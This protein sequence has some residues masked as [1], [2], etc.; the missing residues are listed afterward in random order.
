MDH[1]A[2]TLPLRGRRRCNDL[3][4]QETVFTQPAAIHRPAPIPAYLGQSYQPLIAGMD[5]Y[6]ANGEALFD[7]FP[8]VEFRMHTVE[9]GY[10]VMGNGIDG[11]VLTDDQM[12]IEE[13]SCFADQSA[14]EPNA[15]HLQNA[16]IKGEFDEIFVGFDAAWRNYYHWLC[17]G[18][19]KMWYANTLVSPECKIV[20]PAYAELTADQPAVF[21]QQV[22]EKSISTVGLSDRLT[23][24]VPGVYRAKR[25]KF[26]WHF[27]RMPEMVAHLSP[28]HQYFN[29]VAKKIEPVEGLP[30][31]VLISREESNE[32]R[33]DAGQTELLTRV[34]TKFGF[35]K[36]ILG[37]MSF[38]EQ[39][40]LFKNAKMIIAPHGAGLANMLF[41]GPNL[42]VLEINKF[43]AGQNHLRPCFYIFAS[44]RN[45]NYMFLNSDTDQL[46]EQTLSE[47]IIRLLDA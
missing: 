2:R 28:F 38:A 27:P 1:Y 26:L 29:E 36:A 8:E 42:K 46:T 25:I 32:P 40:N 12:A 14:L 10:V 9:N 41:A 23:F 34:A 43:L 39:C 44:V 19:S 11:V 24:L 20:A 35:K 33:L 47:A 21:T 6:A 5:P 31:Y 18:L 7:N 15:I 37:R 45:Q 17:Y 22:Y 16:E 30:E 4:V 3:H 13:I